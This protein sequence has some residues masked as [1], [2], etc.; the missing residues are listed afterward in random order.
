MNAIKKLLILMSLLIVSIAYFNNFARSL[1][2]VSTNQVKTQS[3]ASMVDADTV[4]DTERKKIEESMID[5]EKIKTAATL[6]INNANAQLAKNEISAV[7][8]AKII[9][10]QN[11]RIEQAEKMLAQII[12]QS[13]EKVQEV[14]TQE[15]YMSQLVSG[16]QDFGARIMA[17]F[18]SGYGYTEQEKDIARAI[19]AELTKQLEELEGVY[20][21]KIEAA[22]AQNKIKLGNELNIIKQEFDNEIYQQQLITGDA[23]ST[24][25][26]LFWTAVGLAGTVAGGALAK[27]YF[28]EEASENL[29]PTEETI[30]ER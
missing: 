2:P 13:V 30:I 28:G 11:Y 15:S 3:K 27:Q 1:K 29:A 4:I 7:E 21:T 5:A 19:I 10:E 22:D 14:D 23:M 6:M 16:I 20:T 8:A 9:G 24:N 17:P 26:K 18:R 25:R 12:S